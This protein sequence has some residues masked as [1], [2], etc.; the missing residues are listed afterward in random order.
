MYLD[1]LLI[2]PVSHGSTKGDFDSSNDREDQLASGQ[3]VDLHSVTILP[4]LHPT[5]LSDL[6]SMMYSPPR[7][8][9]AT[10]QRGRR[11]RMP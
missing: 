11:R 7:R 2:A 8:Y 9:S 5:S 4:T 6:S 10:M 1:L 3:G